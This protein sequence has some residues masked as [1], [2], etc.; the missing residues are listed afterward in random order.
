M[1]WWL[2]GSW[3]IATSALISYLW[4]ERIVRQLCCLQ[5]SHNI[6]IHVFPCTRAALHNTIMRLGYGT[7]PTQPA[8]GCFWCSKY[9]Y[10]NLFGGLPWREG[11]VREC[12]SAAWHKCH[13]WQP[14]FSQGSLPDEAIQ[15]P[16][17]IL[18]TCTAALLYLP[19]SLHKRCSC[20]PVKTCLTKL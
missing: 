14:L 17:Q 2:L 10:V 9:L 19:P 15:N 13:Q 1:W 18:H 6:D 3:W 12:E 5:N 4:L 7:Q 16:A 20:S 11:L 8:S